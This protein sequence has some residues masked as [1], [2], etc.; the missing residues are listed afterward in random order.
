MNKKCKCGG[1]IHS[2]VN[3][4]GLAEC[5]NCHK[6]YVLSNGEWKNI[7]KTRFRVLYREQL[8]EQ[9]KSNK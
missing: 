2:Y 9:Q 6:F 8:I 3:L 5:C 1:H 7:S 4:N